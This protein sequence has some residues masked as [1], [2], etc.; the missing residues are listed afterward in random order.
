MNS[1]FG[2]DESR[3]DY[4]CPVCDGVVAGFTSCWPENVPEYSKADHSNVDD[5]CNI[6]QVSLP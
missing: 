4:W 5:E 2:R 6:E 3:I 1:T